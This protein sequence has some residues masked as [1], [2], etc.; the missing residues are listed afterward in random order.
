MLFGERKGCFSGKHPFSLS[1][2]AA[3][4]WEYNGHR[5]N[6][7]RMIDVKNR[8]VLSYPQYAADGFCIRNPDFV[9]SYVAFVNRDTVG[10]RVP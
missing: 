5:L 8:E 2:E 1:R 4:S 10:G 7:W 6:D 3:A 9:D